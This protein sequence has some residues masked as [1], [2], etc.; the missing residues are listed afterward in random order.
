MNADYTLTDPV[1]VIEGREFGGYA[2]P[3]PRHW[4]VNFSRPQYNGTIEVWAEL[5][6]RVAGETADEAGAKWLADMHD[7]LANVGR[8]TNIGLCLVSIELFAA[9]A[10]SAD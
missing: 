10:P 7:K 8:M 3:Q 2:I 5:R 6:E 9:A 1:T 4:R